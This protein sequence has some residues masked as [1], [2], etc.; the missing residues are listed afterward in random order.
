M[1]KKY[2]TYGSVAAALIVLAIGAFWFFGGSSS[3]L[4]GIT[5]KPTDMVHGSPSAPVTIV[6]YASMTCPH[7]AEF[8]K[9]T[10]PLLTRDYIDSGKV[11]LV[12]REFPLDAAARMASAVARCLPNDQYFSFID[13]LFKNQSDWIKDL[14]GDGQITLKD[15]REGLVQI[16]RF[17]GLSR[18]KVES[19]AEDKNNLALVD[20]NWN[21]GQ[22][23]YKVD[24]TPTFFIN[25]AEHGP[26]AYGELRKILDPLV[27]K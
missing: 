9:D 21:E 1:N 3:A 4:A 11:K 22:T 2:R 12:F 26:M 20:A 7:C 23:K 6:E 14:D 15:I 10:V 16:G 24:G 27:T 5:V 19:C 25:G 8:Q 18:E 17:A 13:M